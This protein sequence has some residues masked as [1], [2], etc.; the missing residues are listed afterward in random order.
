VIMVVERS[1][2]GFGTPGRAIIGAI[3][4][5]GKAHFGVVVCRR[6]RRVGLNITLT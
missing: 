2:A 3:A 6:D 1:D 4:Q 5:I